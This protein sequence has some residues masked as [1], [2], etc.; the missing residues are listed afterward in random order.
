MNFHSTEDVPLNYL[1]GVK[2]KVVVGMEV[3]AS[4]Y[5]LD[6]SMFVKV[7]LYDDRYVIQ[8]DLVPSDRSLRSYL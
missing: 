8:V 6:K 3:C 2:V 7:S 5:S 4:E 1:S